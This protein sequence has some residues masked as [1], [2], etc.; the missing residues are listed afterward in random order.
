METDNFIFHV[1]SGHVYVSIARDAETTFSTS[2]DEVERPLLLGKNK[3]MAGLMKHESGVKNWKSLS[4][5]D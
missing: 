1:I 5:G 2:N 4:H 3:K